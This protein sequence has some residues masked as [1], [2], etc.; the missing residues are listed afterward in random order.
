MKANKIIMTFFILMGMFTAKAQDFYY[1]AELAIISQPVMTYTPNSVRLYYDIQNIGN[2]RYSGY[3]YIYMYPDNGQYYDRE[4][5]RIRPGRIK[6]VVME[7]PYYLFDPNINY[8]VSPYYE[9]GHELF[10]FTTYEYFEP[11]T[12]SW[13]G[14]RTQFYIV[15]APRPLPRLYHRLNVPRYYYDGHRPPHDGYVHG[16][17]YDPRYGHENHLYFGQPNNHPS[18]DHGKPTEP[19]SVNRRGSSTAGSMSERSKNQYNS[20]GNANVVKPRAN[21]NNNGKVSGNDERRKRNSGSD[22][23]SATVRDNNSSSSSSSSG[24][25]RSGSNDS[26]SSR[27]SSRVKDNSSNSSS[28]NG[29]SSRLRSNYSEKKGSDKSKYNQTSSSSSNRGTRNR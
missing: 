15:T 20:S 6:R 5:V 8:V 19:A 13:R 4:Y 2:E 27:G 10:Y 9:I 23:G 28:S 16:Y 1:P 7:I 24:T 22:R 17:P 25:S 12:L 11:L 29:A 18:N 14:P 26:S 3:F 21:G